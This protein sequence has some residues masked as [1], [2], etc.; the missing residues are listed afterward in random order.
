MDKIRAEEEIAAA[1]QAAIDEAAR[2]AALEEEEKHRKKKKKRGKKG[3]TVKKKNSMRASSFGATLGSDD[4]EDD[5][6]PGTAGTTGTVESENSFGTDSRPTSRG[7]MLGAMS[8]FSGLG[9]LATHR[10]DDDDDEE[11][12]DF[13]ED[14]ERSERSQS[15]TSPS[16]NALLPSMGFGDALTS[17]GGSFS[18][19]KSDDT[20]NIKKV[21]EDEEVHPGNSDEA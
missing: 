6:R 10:D 8:P 14:G 18:H 21:L 9:E 13:N 16:V 5:L 7:S 12:D 4:G 1:K 11:Q 3:S 2:L 19:D 20:F 17:G 15:P